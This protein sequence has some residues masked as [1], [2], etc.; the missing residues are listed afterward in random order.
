MADE[1]VLRP[2]TDDRP[3]EV[4]R[5]PSG[6]RIFLAVLVVSTA[7]AAVLASQAISAPE[8]AAV[9]DPD[10]P[11]EPPPSPGFD[12]PDEGLAALI[13]GFDATLQLV[14]FVPSPIVGEPA[15][16]E[17]WVWPSD[18]PPQRIPIFHE[19]LNASFDPSGRW[20]A[21][22]VQAG[23]DRHRLFAGT[24]P[25]LTEIAVGVLDFAWH[26]T[27]PGAVAFLQES[28]GTA[29]IEVGG[30]VEQG[31]VF[32]P[33]GTLDLAPISALRLVT[34]DDGL[35]VEHWAD[36]GSPRLVDL[37]TDGAIL[38][39]SIGRE[40]TDVIPVEAKR[41]DEAAVT[42]SNGRFA[43]ASGGKVDGGHLDLIVDLDTGTAIELPI[44]GIVTA[45]TFAG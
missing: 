43:V 27:T 30:F 24:G 44:P 17:R 19:L 25:E 20:V 16:V 26:E 12:V 45:A 31:I 41:V 21:G 28:D 42:A 39:S 38:G 29:V 7:L 15:I 8:P 10:I 22:L 33:S 35:V 9:T 18:E 6:T 2:V 4:D 3:S 40:T 5:P 14:V 34:Y 23:R 11:A 37:T 36:P 13:P 32:K 1:G